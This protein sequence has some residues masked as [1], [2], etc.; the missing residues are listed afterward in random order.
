LFAPEG[1]G[2][3][4]ASLRSEAAQDPDTRDCLWGDFAGDRPYF[5]VYGK[6]G[7]RKGSF[8]LLAALHR[9]KRRGVDV[10]LV[11]LAHGGAAVE[12]RWRAEASELG[13]KDRILQIPFLPHWRV[14]AF[15]RG[16]L[17]VCCLEQDFSIAIH[18]PIMPR[19]VLMS[20]TCLVGATEIIRKLPS[21]WQ[22]PHGYG[23][24]A[25]KD[26]NDVETLS[27]RLAAIV[28]DPGTA[29]EIGKRG[30]DFACG[31]QRDMSFPQ[32]LEHILQHAAAR[33]RPPSAARPPA[34]NARSSGRS[35]RS[36][37]TWR[38]AAAMPEISDRPQHARLISAEGVADLTADLIWARQVLEAIES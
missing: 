16:C 4:L 32:R 9:L 25:I 1:D 27:E 29:A 6:L 36:P 28:E 13:L 24:V 22:L 17:A 21:F 30:C 5:G 33:Q 3:D 12:E 34:E 31:V 38:V 15:L 18:S 26:V 23:C 37:L 20:G 35:L 14:P 7:E 19:E 10:G 2:L 8:A 11:A